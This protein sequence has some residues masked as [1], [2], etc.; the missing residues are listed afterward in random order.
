MTASVNING[1]LSNLSL[2]SQRVISFKFTGW[3]TSEIQRVQA[4][5]N[6][7]ALRNAA[8][9]QQTPNPVVHCTLTL[10]T[11]TSALCNNFTTFVWPPALDSVRAVSPSCK[12][13]D[14]YVLY[15]LQLE[16]QPSLIKNLKQHSRL[17]RCRAYYKGR[18]RQSKC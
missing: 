15:T 9:K 10:C 18:E 14:R 3:S 16:A 5:D 13:F 2:R 12:E 8:I 4:S 7:F 17:R 1:S 6:H 11:L